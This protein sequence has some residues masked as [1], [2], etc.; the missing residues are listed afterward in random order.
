MNNCITFI[1]YILGRIIIIDNLGLLTRSVIHLLTNVNCLSGTHEHFIHH[2]LSMQLF[3]FVSALHS[4]IKGKLDQKC[5][6]P[7]AHMILIMT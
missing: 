7:L 4:E 5:N 1:N 3:S 6:L 2:A